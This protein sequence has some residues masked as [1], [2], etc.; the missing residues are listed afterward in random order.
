MPYITSIAIRG[1][2]ALNLDFYKFW[3]E[4]EKVALIDEVEC[5]EYHQYVLR[6]LIKRAFED[7][8]IP[9]DL[10]WARPLVK[11][12]FASQKAKGIEQPFVY[13]TIRHGRVSSFNDDVW[14][15]DG[16][17]MNIT[18]LP[19]QNYIWTNVMPTEYVVKGIH[20]PYDFDPKRHN[21]HTLL[22]DEVKN[23]SVQTME[24]KVLYAMDPYIIHRRPNNIP[25]ALQRTFV[26]ISFTP[27]E[28]MDDNNTP[29][30][31]LKVR[32]YGRDGIKDFR[33]KLI[34]YK[35]D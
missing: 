21:I 9:E 1:K 4:P 35:K 13:L 23:V 27:I 20:F 14:H 26:R 10:L 30:P 28:I 2:S 3:N 32:K 24:P 31:L 12:A 19:E 34:D 22:Q 17:S 5:G 6:M 16:F 8:K 7:V 29:N 11:A 15:V 25:D 33:E 18:H